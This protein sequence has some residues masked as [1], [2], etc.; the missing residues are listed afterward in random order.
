[1]DHHPDNPSSNQLPPGVPEE[2]LIDAVQ[3]SGYPLQSLV[4]R[5]LSNEFQVVEEWGYSDRTEKSHR[6]LDVYAFRELHSRGPVKPRFHLLVEC[7]RSDLPYVFFVPGADRKMRG[8]P[9]ILA[10]ANNYQLR[11]ERGHREISAAE[12]FCAAEL[13]FISPG[14]TISTSFTR[15]ERKKKEFDLTGEVPFKQVVLPLASALEHLRS[16]WHGTPQSPVIVLA[17]C[18]V[19]ATMVVARG[20]P[21][22]AGLTAEPWARVVHQEAIQ[23]Q[24]RWVARNYV[25]DCVHRRYLRKYVDEHAIPFAESFADRMVRYHNRV[26]KG[27]HQRPEN[28]AWSQFAETVALGE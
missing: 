4:A 14:P 20:T 13:P 18:V 2:K 8:F 25:V 15:A 1:M 22:Y 16:F 26:T 11:L 23:E 24:D 17:I 27:P 12:F 28:L 10:S 9:D 5:E 3:K 6:S 7:K 21:E 19:D